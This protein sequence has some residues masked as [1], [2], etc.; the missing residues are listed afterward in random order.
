[1]HLSISVA[2]L[3]FSYSGSTRCLLYEVITAEKYTPRWQVQLEVDQI[4]DLSASN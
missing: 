1:M 2:I 3:V 4:H